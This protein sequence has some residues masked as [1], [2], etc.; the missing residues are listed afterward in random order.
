VVTSVALALMATGGRA[1]VSASPSAPAS[2]NTGASTQH[3]ANSAPTT[4]SLGARKARSGHA[5]TTATANPGATTDTGPGAAEDSAAARARATGKP[6]IVDQETTA[7]TEVTAHPDGKLSF[8]SYAQPVRI[9]RN[10]TWIPIDPTLHPTAA[11]FTATDTNDPVSFSAGGTT[12]LLTLTDPATAKTVSVSWPWSLPTPTIS[13]DTA[14][15]VDVLPGVDLRM[16]ATATGYT[17]VLIVHD[18]T[19]AADP[20][21]RALTLTLHAS[22]GARITDGPGGTLTVT[23]ST[24]GATLFTAGTAIMWD[25]HRD[26]AGMTSPS[27]DDAGSGHRIQVPTTSTIRPNGDATLTMVPPTAALTGPGVTYPLF[28]D[29]PQNGNRLYYAQVADYGGVWNTTKNDTSIGNGR[30]EIGY[31][32]YSS[33]A[34]YWNGGGP[35]YYYKMRTYFQMDTSDLKLRDNNTLKATVYSATFNDE[36]IA[37]SENNCSVA[38]ATALYSAGGIGSDTTWPGPEGAYIS[39]TSSAVGAT[40]SCPGANVAFEATSIATTAA[41]NG[42][43]SVNLELRPVDFTDE[44]QYKVFS[45]NPTL[46]VYY[47]FPPSAPDM[48]TISNP[49]TCTGT[50]YTSDALPTLTAQVTDNNPS[51][52]PDYLFFEVWNSTGTTR[53]AWN[54]AGLQTASNTPYPWTVVHSGGLS[55]AFEFRVRAET[56]L[57]PKDQAQPLFSPW[58]VWFPFTDLSNPPT[59]AP[60]IST[61]DYPA[62]QWGQP[63]GAPGIFTVGTGGASDIAGFTYTFDGGSGSEWIPDCN[64]LLDGGNGS[65]TSSGGATYG[66]VA[67]RSG[68]TTQIRVPNLAVGK[69]TLDVL[70][71]DQAG[72]VSQQETEYVFYVSPN[73]QA[74]SQPAQFINGDTLAATTEA[75][76][77]LISTQPN[78]CGLT[79]R[80]GKQLYFNGTAQGDAFTVKFTVA[81]AGTWQ[82]AAD[83]TKSFDYGQFQIDLD[84]TTNLAGTANQPWDGYAPVSHYFL[85]LG[86]PTFTAGSVHT[87]TFTAVGQNPN[88][89]AYRLGINYLELFP[90]VRLQAVSLT[91]TTPTHGNLWTQTWGS[92]L[93]SDNQQLAL[94]SNTVSGTSFMVHF[95]APVE[96]DYALGINLTKAGN[97]GT[98]RFDLD[99]SINLAGTATTPFDANSANVVTVYKFLGGAHL[100]AGD[101]TLTITVSG[102]NSASLLCGFDFLQVAAVNNYTVASLTSGMNNLGI[103]T[104]S[105][106]GAATAAS[107]DGGAANN[108]S[109]TALNL[110]GIVP[111]TGTTT[112]TTFMMGGATFTMP[113]LLKDS[114]GTIVGDNVVAA[115]QTVI[116]SPQQQQN[117]TAV[118]LLVAATCGASPVGTATISYTQASAVQPSQSSFP[119]VPDWISGPSSTAAVV[120]DHEDSGT[121]PDAAKQPH[122][123]EV[124]LPVNPKGVLYSVTLPVG[125]TTFLPG[126]CPQ[127]LHVLALGTRTVDVPP[128]GLTPPAGIWVGAY[129]APMDTAIA[130]AGGSMTD[131]TLREEI[132]PSVPGGGYVRIHLSNAHSTRPVTFDAASIAAQSTGQ[133][134]LAAPTAL[135]FH[136]GSANVTIPAGGDVY[137]DYTQLPGTSGGT[138]NLTISLHIPA[139]NPVTLAPIHETTGATTHYAGGNNTTDS[140]GTMF[141]NANSTAG[142]Y[143]LAGVDVSDPNPNT[144]DGTVAIL[145]DGTAAAAPPGSTNTWG[146]DL[147]AA[148]AANGVALPGAVANDSTAATNPFAWWR[149][150]EGSGTAAYDGAG[151]NSATLT[152]AGWSTSAPGTGTVTGSVSLNGTGGYVVTSGAVLD[153]SSTFTVSAWVKLSAIP[154]HDAVVAAQ[155]G[156]SASG[157]YLGYTVANN[158]WTFRFATA[159]TASPTWQPSSSGSGVTTNWTHLVGVYDATAGTATLYVNGVSA[160]SATGVTAWPAPKGFTIGRALIGGAAA[161][162]FPG[163]VTDVRAWK[164]ALSRTQVSAVYHDNGTSTLTTANA[165]AAFNNTAAAEPNLRDVIVSVGATDVLKGGPTQQAIDQT[166][167]DNLGPLI[168][169]LKQRQLNNGSNLAIGVF[170]TTIA[171]LGLPSTDPR[172]KA[173][174]DI[175]NW[176]MHNSGATMAIDT[177]TP[178]TDP[179]NAN[180]IAPTYLTGGA[181]NASYYTQIA[182]AIGLA[183]ANAIPPTTL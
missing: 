114:S 78:C 175:N 69:H 91:H 133:S 80:A 34:Y 138:G 5:A 168:V 59:Q 35:F 149:L 145:G 25:S 131:L 40:P 179:N 88:S 159:D 1:L 52:L 45:D 139:A 71:F 169:E 55:G 109:L 155:D 73:F 110:A 68:T 95:T 162:F 148:L 173:R 38:E 12:H 44:L 26:Q 3:E 182:N 90:T 31:C 82:L 118:A 102:T 151:A 183:F 164:S 66:E 83:M 92:P 99:S 6:V 63:T 21:L 142:L 156:N 42:S 30:V 20:R 62:N 32:G 107:F 127:A 87:L 141:T 116:L 123:Y 67:L 163:S 39:Q 134:T 172:E 170:V 126:T 19:A 43:A 157:F 29:P 154:T 150:D 93:W 113:Q 136:G 176:I 122:L 94:A 10:G 7:T 64:Y 53:V 70:S 16:K 46:T 79:W 97:Y 15:Y 124:I 128:T 104:D 115:G 37:A 23:D 160:G 28:I 111:G 51:P 137:S 47:N 84:G 13:G 152:G 33:C 178:V 27:A 103:A 100:T 177:A 171:P 81:K 161:D 167:E 119:S 158:E 18:A 60:T 143:Y 76:N 41:N 140:T 165:L 153:T 61:Y 96:A 174:E 77:P 85:D 72:N 8:T 135:S 4:R 49:T 56:V 101:H 75:S 121:T 14:T 54:T 36:Q 108:L 86:T 9:Q 17:Q 2:N 74:V 58:S 120:L 65:S 129:A 166:V 117:A 132:T 112:G 147:P 125:M 57:P 106:T 146:A 48:L 98:L 50:T 130:P 181:P 180:L 24:S 105:T 22:T 11:G 144:T 89:G